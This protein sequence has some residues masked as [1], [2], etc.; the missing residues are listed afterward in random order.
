M[1][2]ETN[3]F[4]IAYDGEN[5]VCCFPLLDDIASGDLLLSA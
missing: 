4:Q 3:E 1:T 2:S 5:D